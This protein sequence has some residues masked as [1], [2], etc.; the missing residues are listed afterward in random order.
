M[1]VS[2]NPIETDESN[3]YQYPTESRPMDPM[4]INSN[5]IEIGEDRES[6]GEHESPVIEKEPKP[7]VT[8]PL[9]LAPMR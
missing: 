7:N 8:I 3:E 6:T 1:K 4:N 9:Y 2:S 5:R